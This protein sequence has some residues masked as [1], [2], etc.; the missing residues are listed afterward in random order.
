LAAVSVAIPTTPLTTGTTTFPTV[1]PQAVASQV[2]VVIDRS[3]AGGLDATPGATITIE[4]DRF[5]GGQWVF[6][7]GCTT[8][9][10]PLTPDRHGVTAHVTT[11]FFGTDAFP[12]RMRV[13][14]TG[15]PV[16]IG[17]GS[18]TMTVQ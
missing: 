4:L 10:G 13:T 8:I 3:V 7:A 18:S 14:C 11:M 5:I 17:G 1:T 9:G 15:D 12:H 2:S 6:W 16:T